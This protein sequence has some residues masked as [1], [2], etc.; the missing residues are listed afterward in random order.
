MFIP[1]FWLN[2]FYGHLSRRIYI[3]LIADAGYI[4]NAVLMLV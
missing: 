2:H 1:P 3:S 4:I